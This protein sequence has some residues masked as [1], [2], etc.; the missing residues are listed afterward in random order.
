MGRVLY[1]GRL[2]VTLPGQRYDAASG[3]NYNYQ[4]DYDTGSGRYVESDPIGLAGGISTFGYVKRNPLL[5]IDPTGLVVK[6][7]CRKAQIAFGL[8]SHCWLKTDTKVAGMNAQAQCSRAGD[9][10]SNLPWVTPVVVSDHSCEVSE[11]CE[12]IPDVDE[13]CVNRELTIGRDLGR[14]GML[15]NCQT[16]AWAVLTK[17]QKN[18]RPHPKPS[19][20]F[21]AK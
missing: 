15:N 21:L 2:V 6:R 1:R 7:C 12:T 19:L 20:R 13:E 5:N 8:V 10:G 4:R 14:F 16:F 18:P 11:N 3:L 9:G 17:C